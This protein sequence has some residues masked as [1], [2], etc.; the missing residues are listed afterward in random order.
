[1]SLILKFNSHVWEI[2]KNM[3]VCP[4]LF[5]LVYYI[6]NN[7][8]ITRSMFIVYIIIIVRLIYIHTIRKLFSL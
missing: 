2:L 3:V 7:K 8:Q 5:L 6:Y 1:M 4:V